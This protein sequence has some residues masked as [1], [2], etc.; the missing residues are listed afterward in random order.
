MCNKIFFIF[1]FTLKDGQRVGEASPPSPT[2]KARA[3]PLILT[4]MESRSAGHQALSEIV[5]RI[6][7]T[8]SLFAMSQMNAIFGFTSPSQWN[9]NLRVTPMN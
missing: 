3:L 6:R 5:K 1:I 2:R 9:D 7:H 4:D 8:V